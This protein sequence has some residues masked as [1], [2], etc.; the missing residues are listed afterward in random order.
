MK[1]LHILIDLFFSVLERKK[2]ATT[3]DEQNLIN[4]NSKIENGEYKVLVTTFVKRFITSDRTNQD[5]N[6]GNQ[7]QKQINEFFVYQKIEVSISCKI[8]TFF[9]F[10]FLRYTWWSLCIL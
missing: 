5:I 3:D 7:H 9:N 4:G 1:F 2:E 10:I 8:Q 6:I